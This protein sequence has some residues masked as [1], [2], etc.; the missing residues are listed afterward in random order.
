M[1]N[2]DI[3]D[4]EVAFLVM[5]VS[6]GGLAVTALLHLVFAFAVVADAGKPPHRGRTI[7]VGRVTWFF[8]VLIGG[9]FVAG[10]YWIMHHSTLC[11]WA[12]EMALR[13]RD[14]TV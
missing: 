7:L 12:M 13:K 14:D 2:L 6:Y 5:A 4:P 3:S 10:M 8:A 1:F 9:P 11:P